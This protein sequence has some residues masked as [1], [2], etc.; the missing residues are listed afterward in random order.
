ME[1]TGNGNGVVDYIATSLWLARDV[2]YRERGDGL[3]NVDML[4]APSLYLAVGAIRESRG[5]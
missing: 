2:L 3:E 1:A 4:M 5:V